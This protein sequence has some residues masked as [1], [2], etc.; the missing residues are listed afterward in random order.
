[1]KMEKKKI[2]ILVIVVI[3][4][5]LILNKG[6]GLL[7]Y[8]SSML[9]GSGIN[10]TSSMYYSGTGEG[11]NYSCETKEFTGM[12]TI[13]KYNSKNE[14]SIPGKFNMSINSGKSKIVLIDGSGKQT[15]LF[16]I[17]A[18]GDE[19]HEFEIALP[20]TEGENIL[21]LVSFNVNDLDVQINV[22]K[23]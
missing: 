4:V 6:F 16:E 17:V 21:R 9:I 8:N 3:G 23:K 18:R 14:K 2:I 22:P 11:E 7:T 15:T 19:K 1:M 10:Q 13:W 12:I 20:I 5:V